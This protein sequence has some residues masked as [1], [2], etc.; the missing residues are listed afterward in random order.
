ML[1]S[2]LILLGFFAFSTSVMADDWLFVGT[3][4]GKNS[5]GIYRLSLDPKT[6]KLGE[7]V[8]A[9][10]TVSPSFLAVHPSKKFLYAVNEISMFNGQKAGA[11]S[12]FAL[13]ATSGELKFLNQQSSVGTGPC[14]LSI[15]PAGKFVLVANYGGGSVLALPIEADGKLAP[16]SSFVQHEGSSIKSNQKGPHAHSI[17]MDPQGRFVLAADLGLDKVMLYRLKEGKLIANNPPAGVL[18]PGSGPRHLD[19]DAA[20]KFV[21]VVNEN[22]STVTVFEL[23]ADGAMTE[24]QTITTLPENAGDVRNS[25]AEIRVHRDLGFVY[26]SNRG[27]DSIAIFKADP[28]TGKLTAVGHQN[29]LVKTPRNFTPHGNLLLVASQA[30]NK[31]VVFQIDAKTGELRPTDFVAEVGAPVCLRVVTK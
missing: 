12:A 6:G 5:K 25:T 10:E 3:Y 8:L 1:R 13:D 30:S 28:K 31:V 24:I 26:A 19:L 27:H 14:H 22:A 16:A 17:N 21:Y 15:D 23:A 29:H 4:T 18:K 11:V 20:G 7:P 2:F 9:A